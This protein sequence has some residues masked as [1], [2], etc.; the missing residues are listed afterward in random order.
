MSLNMT[1]LEVVEIEMNYLRE[2]LGVGRVYMV[3]LYL[4]RIKPLESAQVPVEWF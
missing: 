3:S 2:H 1:N 4:G